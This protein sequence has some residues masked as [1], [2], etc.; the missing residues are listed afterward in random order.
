MS[1]IYSYCF[2]RHLSLSVPECS[3]HAL[4]A[5]ASSTLSFAFFFLLHHVCMPYYEVPCLHTRRQGRARYVSEQSAI[6][7]AAAMC[8]C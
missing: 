3:L 1:V 6:R 4:R 8:C 7:A 5:P 2:S